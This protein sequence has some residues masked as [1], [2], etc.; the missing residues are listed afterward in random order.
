ME[1]STARAV[2]VGS[3]VRLEARVRGVSQRVLVGGR[4]PEWRVGGALAVR[5]GMLCGLAEGG[6]TVRAKV[7]G[8]WSAEK[9]VSV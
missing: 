9:E 3:C 1:V 2:C 4:E 6:A 7:A 8:V 5:A